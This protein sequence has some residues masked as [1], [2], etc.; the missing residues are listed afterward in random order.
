LFSSFIERLERDI[1]ET[2]ARQAELQEELDQLDLSDS[3]LGTDLESR[4]SEDSDKENMA[5]FG[6]NW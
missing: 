4:E 1:R 6:D 2:E 5:P 3:E